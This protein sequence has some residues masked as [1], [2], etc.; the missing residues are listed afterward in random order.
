MK[1][2]RYIY[3]TLLFA[4]IVGATRPAAAQ[5]SLSLQEAVRLADL[6]NRE[7]LESQL[8]VEQAA[9]QRIIARALYLPSVNAQAGVNHYFDLPP[10]F[11]FGETSSE[12][13]VPYGRFGGKDQ[14]NASVSAVQPIYNPL[15]I[16]SLHHARLQ[17]RESQ[18]TLQGRRQEVLASLREAYLRVLVLN[19][20]IKLQQESI[21]RNNR[22]L[23]DSRSLLLQG[24]GLRVDTLRA[25][26][27][28]RNLE[29]E[30]LRLSFAVETSTL[31]LK[32]LIGVDSLQDIVL[33]DSLVVPVSV[34]V[35][36]EEDV[37]AAAKRNN[38]YF[39]SLALKEQLESQQVRMT[40]SLRKPQ[41]SAVA[42]YQV[43]SHTNSFDYGNAYYP[44]ASFV[45]LQLSVPL[46]AGFSSQA[47]VKKASLGRQQ[48]VLRQQHAHEQLRASVHQA[49]A[50]RQE[51]FARL[52]TASVTR[53]TARLSYTIIQ[54]RY[55]SGISAR[56]ELTDAELALSTAQSNY[57]EAVYDYLSA[58]IA[59]NKLQ[60]IAD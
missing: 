7:I 5:Q 6:H 31:Q 60:G 14:L 45:G 2:L 24:K 9:Q 27:A 16:P 46:F 57:L 28:V 51:S 58:G 38:P 18:A 22:V 53:E 15:A 19:E 37:Y 8:G 44:S 20:R 36:S 33:T 29:P 21:R 50:A 25:Y 4:L 40:S 30:L 39:Q 35:P 56:L 52:E 10:F 47:K 1:P 42:Q 43:Q 26:T 49:L 3:R 48:A 54:Y 12:G 41:L 13:K 59:L 32:T 17:E 23:Q 11:G 55:K 34:A